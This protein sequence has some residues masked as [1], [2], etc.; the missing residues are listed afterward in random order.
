MSRID[1]FT[2]LLIILLLLLLTVTF[3]LNGE[4]VCLLPIL[5]ICLRI[6]IFLAFFDLF[7][8]VVHLAFNNFLRLWLMSNN[9]LRFVLLELFFSNE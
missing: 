1:F 7:D 4:V 6:L 2:I 9:R 8:I 5:T 3:L